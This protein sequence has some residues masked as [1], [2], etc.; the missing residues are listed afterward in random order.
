MYEGENQCDKS[1]ILSRNFHLQLIPG[2]SIGKQIER[3]LNT[4]KQSQYIL[5]LS[6]AGCSKT[7]FKT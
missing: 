3:D 6:A 5:S 7:I 2:L 1:S 4:S